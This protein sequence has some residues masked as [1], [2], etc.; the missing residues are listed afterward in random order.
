MAPASVEIPAPLVGAVRGSVVLLYE[1]AV[2]A[3]H[4]ALRSRA[5][6]GEPHDETQ[7]CRARVA[8]LDALLVQL[9]WW[10]DP[11]PEGIAGRVELSAPRGVL[12]DAVYGGLIDAGERLAV[13]CGECW[14]AGA[15]P[16]KVRAAAVEVIALDRL[17]ADLRSA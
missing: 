1:S 9:G 10:A 16:E 5:E 8:E 12:H 4:F 3:L 15:G 2:E 11:A 7:R 14:R 6:H 13:A 17:L